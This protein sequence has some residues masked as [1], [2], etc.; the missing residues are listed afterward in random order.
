MS[1]RLRQIKRRYIGT[2]KPQQNHVV[3]D[4]DVCALKS[5]ALIKSERRRIF[6]MAFQ[7]ERMVAVLAVKGR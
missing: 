2:R 4:A 6:D 5:K 1:L 3:S 7:Q